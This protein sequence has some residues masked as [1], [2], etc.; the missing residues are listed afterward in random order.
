[1]STT[2]N[3]NDAKEHDMDPKTSCAWLASGQ[4]SPR[5]RHTGSWRAGCPGS[6]RRLGPISTC[7]IPG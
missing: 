1:M 7:A 3:V 5:R 6:L 4:R 2:S